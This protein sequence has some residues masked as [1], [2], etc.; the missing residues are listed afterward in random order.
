MAFLGYLASYCLFSIN[1][2]FFFVCVW[3]KIK[4]KKKKILIGLNQ[5][6][7]VG[8]INNLI[9]QVMVVQK[10]SVTATVAVTNNSPF[11]DYPTWTITLQLLQLNIIN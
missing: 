1:I 9:V 5:R 7:S 3:Q 10:K 6:V 2:L 4:N 8:H 11:Q